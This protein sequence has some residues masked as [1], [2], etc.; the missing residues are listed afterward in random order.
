MLKQQK[1]VKKKKKKKLLNTIRT[2]K[3]EPFTLTFFY[4]YWPEK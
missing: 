2:N 3:K 1:A 4:P